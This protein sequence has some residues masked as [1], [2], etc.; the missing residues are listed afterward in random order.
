[1]GIVGVV[2]ADLHVHPGGAAEVKARIGIA[3][4][5]VEMRRHPPTGTLS[6]Q[7]L[8]GKGG[9]TKHIG[10]RSVGAETACQLIGCEARTLGQSCPCPQL[11]PDVNH[12]G[13]V[14]SRDQFV[15]LA[16]LIGQGRRCHRTRLRVHLFS[17]FTCRVT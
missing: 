15:E 1:M 13:R 2:L 4:D 9:A 8:E 7:Q 12:M 10:V 6:F 14:V 5:L 16:D 3:E 11:A 17:L